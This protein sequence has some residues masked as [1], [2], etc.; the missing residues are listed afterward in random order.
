M[1]EVV[2]ITYRL[3]KGRSQRLSQRYESRLKD[4][5]E[6]LRVCGKERMFFSESISA[7]T[8]DGC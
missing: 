7:N 6:V 8:G 3:R 1:N 4:G 5:E 2:E